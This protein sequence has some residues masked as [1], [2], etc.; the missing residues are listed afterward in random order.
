MPSDVINLNLVNASADCNNSSIVLF[1]KNVVPSIQ[2]LAVAWLVIENLGIGWNHPFT[3]DYGLQVSAHDSWGNSIRP[4]DSDNGALWKVVHDCSGD[5]LQLAGAAT[6][7]TEVQILNG[8]TRGAIS[9]N[10][11]RSGTLLATKTG[12]APGQ[13]AAFRFNPVLYVGVVSQVEQGKVLDSAILSSINTSLSLSGLASADIV[14]TGG[15]PGKNSAPFT[16][17][18]QNKVFMA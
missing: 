15:G 1:Q 8:L 5:Q 18:L 3:Y 10:V 11:Y 2:E 4:K 17:T 13:F 12:V 6:V 7:P 14:M 16:F 9:A